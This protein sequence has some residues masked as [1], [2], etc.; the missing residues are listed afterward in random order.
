M[1][2]SHCVMHFIAKGVYKITFY[3]LIKHGTIERK[4]DSEQQLL[5]LK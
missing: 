4:P 2:K 3:D 1:R 5:W